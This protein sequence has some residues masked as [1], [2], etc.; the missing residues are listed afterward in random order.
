MDD[1][2]N[3]LGKLIV[4]EVKKQILLMDLV[5]T[6]EYLNSVKYEIHSGRLYIIVDTP[7]AEALEYGTYN[8][9]SKNETD[10]PE[11]AKDSKSMKKK[12]MD[13]L[14]ASK[15]PKGMIAFAPIRRVLYNQRLMQDL[16]NLAFA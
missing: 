8:L 13:I 16:V 10:F 14:T 15:L 4:R 6:G 12:D 2:L 11:T 1:P 7:Y 3:K 5:D 9:A